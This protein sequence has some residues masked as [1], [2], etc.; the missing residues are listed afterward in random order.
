MLTHRTQAVVAAIFAAT[1]FAPAL[2]RAQERDPA[3]AQA[4]FDQGQALVNAGRYAEACAKLAESQR[5]DPGIGTEFHLAACHEL[6]GKLASAWAEF[7]E[8]ASLASASRQD[9]RAKA[10]SRRASLLEPRLPRLKVVVPAAS[11]APGL[12]V[13]RDG[14]VVGEAQWDLLVPVDPGTRQLEVTAPNR[15]AFAS[16]VTVAEGATTTFE[17]PVLVDAPVV[18][19]GGTAASVVSDAPPSTATLASQS[20]DAS[21]PPSLPEDEPTS[22]SSS[23]PSGL[24]LGLGIGGIVVVG[25]G[26]VLGLMAM[27]QNDKSKDHCQSDDPNRC[28][29][30]GVDQRDDAFLFGNLSTVGFAVGGAAIAAAV[31]LWIADGGDEK[32]D[33]SS[34]RISAGPGGVSVLGAF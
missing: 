26:S 5:L 13:T 4:L 27:S 25:A 30:I 23:G 15:R 31:V 14:V 34:A 24:V 19:V 28:D 10:A 17:V 3:A 2:A 1:S 32:P 29:K 9:A 21:A 8:V 16:A 6:E 18:A 33:G 20:A 12:E 22:E 11:R 7:L